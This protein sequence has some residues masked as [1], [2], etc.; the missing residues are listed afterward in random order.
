MVDGPRECKEKAL[1][2]VKECTKFETATAAF[3]AYHSVGIH[4][5]I[6]AIRVEQIEA[7]L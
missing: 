3:R 2:S 1:E 7:L 4:I 6:D 5:R